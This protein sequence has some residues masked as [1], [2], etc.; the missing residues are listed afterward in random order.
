MSKV[1]NS[2]TTLRG[3]GAVGLII[4]LFYLAHK[5]KETNSDPYKK[6]DNY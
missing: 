5:Y 1:M 4:L 3:T 2:K 6:P